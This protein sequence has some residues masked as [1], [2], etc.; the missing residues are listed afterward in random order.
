MFLKAVGVGEILGDYFGERLDF[1]DYY[2]TCEN[3]AYV[4]KNSSTDA[5]EDR[6]TINQRDGVDTE[7]RIK[8]FKDWA[9]GY[10]Y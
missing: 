10:F 5:E 9:Q 4:V 2:V 3:D 1:G 6:L 7:D 8:K